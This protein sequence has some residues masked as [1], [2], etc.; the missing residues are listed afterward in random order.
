MAEP[1]VGVYRI[2]RYPDHDKI[3]F[4]ANDDAVNLFRR[5]FPLR[6]EEAKR[7]Y[8]GGYYTWLR[9]EARAG[10]YDLVN[11]FFRQYYV[12]PEIKLGLFAG[13]KVLPDTWPARVWIGKVVDGIKMAFS[14]F[15]IEEEGEGWT[16]IYQRKPILAQEGVTV[17]RGVRFRV[18]MDDDSRPILLCDAKHKFHLDD[19]PASLK[20]I[21]RRLGDDEVLM[22]QIKDKT[23]RSTDSHFNTYRWFVQKIGA[24]PGCEDM[25]FGPEPL[26]AS[27]LKYETWF[28]LHDTDTQI[29]IANGIHTNLSQVLLSDGGGFYYQ[30]DDIQI[31][32]LLP[33]E[34]SSTVVPTGDWSRISQLAEDYVQ[35]A[36]PQVDKPF[37]VVKY[38]LVPDQ[39]DYLDQVK[40]FVSE[41]PTRRLLTLMII[42]EKDPSVSQTEAGG[43]AE[44]RSWSVQKAVRSVARGGYVITLGWDCIAKPEELNYFVDNSVTRGLYQIGARP[45]HLVSPPIGSHDP[46]EILFIGLAH[47]TDM[48]QLTGVAFGADGATIGYSGVRATSSKTDFGGLVGQVVGELFGLRQS[49]APSPLQRVVVHVP[50]AIEGYAEQLTSILVKRGIACDAVSISFSGGPRLC[51]PGNDSGTPSNGIAVGNEQVAYLI[52]SHTV[53]EQLHSNKWVLPAP[54]TVVVRRI[55]GE[56][57]MHLL[58]AQVFWFAAMHV[59]AIHRTVDT[60]MTLDF[61]DRLRQYL[62]KSKKDMHPTLADEKVMF[63][64]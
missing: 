14:D 27:E 49:Y 11:R 31:L 38:S 41:Y 47:D 24:L 18:E 64:F 44:A 25:E 28:W 36:L 63:W 19:Q 57:P 6:V 48:S 39:D 5:T 43:A 54:N 45:W 50:A 42:P 16:A 21:S 51:Q 12:P 1:R 3:I 62:G 61:A 53:G 22:K 33:D 59:N 40:A 29:E 58:A 46:S 9:F 26:A 37:T 15:V 7:G 23:T 20:T 52:N 2:T 35:H 56:T 32:L 55:A 13:T 8:E 60:P 30:P 4:Q 17:Y 10:L 34:T